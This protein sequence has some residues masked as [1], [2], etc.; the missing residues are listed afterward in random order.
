MSSDK[1]TDLTSVTSPQTKKNTQTLTAV[2]VSAAETKSKFKHLTISASDDDPLASILRACSNT[3]VK[4]YTDKVF[5]PQ[6]SS[7]LGEGITHDATTTERALY[8]QWKR[9]ENINIA[10]K[11]PVLFA[12]VDPSNILQVCVCVCAV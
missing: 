10:D 5:G 1:N 3:P 7:L 4:R 8:V 12:S 6:L 2:A 9:P 11:A